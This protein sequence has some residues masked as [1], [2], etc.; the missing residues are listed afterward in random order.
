MI[1]LDTN[2]LSEPLRPQPDPRAVAW[3]DAQVVETLYLTTIGLAEIRL[4]IATLSLGRRQDSLRQRFEDA[5]LPVFGTRILPFDER[6]SAVYASMRAAARNA[7]RELPEMDALIAAIVKSNELT[8]ATGDT[9]PFVAA[10]VPV[11]NP[12]D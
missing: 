11:I 1:V 3:L 5:V 8:I 2:V 12:F 6:A 4:G 7:G 9:G 10:G